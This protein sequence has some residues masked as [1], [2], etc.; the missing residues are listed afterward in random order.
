[1]A[2]VLV[3]VQYLILVAGMF[4]LAQ[5]V[6]ALFNWN[7]RGQNVIYGLF[8]LLTRPFVQMARALTPRIVLDQHVPL[9]AFLLLFLAYWVVVFSLYAVCS[10]DLT[11]RGCERLAQRHAGQPR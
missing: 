3:V 2:L 4:L 10:S 6:V 1:M 8:S 7:R 11:Q 9:V 5:F